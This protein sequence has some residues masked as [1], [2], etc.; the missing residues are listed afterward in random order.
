[1]K[2]P[3]IAIVLGSKSDLP[4]LAD[5]EPLLARFGIAHRVLVASA[6]RQP[7]KVAG[8]A[9][10]AERDGFEVIIGCAGYAAPLPGVIAAL[11]SLPISAWPRASARSARRR[12]AAPA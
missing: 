7:A 6:H 8:F 3:K 2:A 4:Y 12:R 1:M 11:T 10:R 5:V 9:R